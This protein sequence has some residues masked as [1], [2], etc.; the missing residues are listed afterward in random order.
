MS[1]ENSYESSPDC[2]DESPA[3]PVTGARKVLY[4]T[5]AGVFFVLGAAGVILPG[6]PTT[7]F[8][9]LTS[10]FLLRASPELNERLLKS[11]MFGP[12]L[13]DW[14]KR[15]GVRRHIKV[16]AIAV[17]VIVVGLM[18]WLSPLTFVWKLVVLGV[19]LVG[20]AV[21]IRLPEVP[22]ASK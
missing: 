2:V 17:V 9:L 5:L 20:L 19:A 13:T 7:P 16:K 6:L 14:Q 21:V 10:Y 4:L 22:N 1:D 18:L 8:L 15:G 3:P 11:R 12:I